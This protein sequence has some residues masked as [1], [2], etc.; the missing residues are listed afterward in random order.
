MKKHSGI[1]MIE[2]IFAIVIIAISVLTIPSMMNIADESAKGIMID[3]DVLKRMSE[4]IV[5]VSK[6]RWDQNYSDETNASDAQYKVLQISNECW[7][8]GGVWRRR[9]SDSLM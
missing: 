4:E 1:A 6:A 8:D 9:N 3:E 7:D 5:K 2:L